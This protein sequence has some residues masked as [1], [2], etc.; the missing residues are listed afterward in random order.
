MPI[1]EVQL[2]YH[3][4]INGE[5]HEWDY[6]VLITEEDIED[7]FGKPIHKDLFCYLDFERLAEDDESFHHYLMQKHEEQAKQEC[8]EYYLEWALNY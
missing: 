6:N 7:Y 4:L 1:N 8:K 5:H 2:T 3:F